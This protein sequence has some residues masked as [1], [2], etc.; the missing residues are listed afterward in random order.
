[1]RDNSW[2]SILGVIKTGDWGGFLLEKYDFFFLSLAIL[3]NDK[4]CSLCNFKSVKG[5]ALHCNVT[6]ECV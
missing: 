6:E 2:T 3:K 5:E 1:M 4:N